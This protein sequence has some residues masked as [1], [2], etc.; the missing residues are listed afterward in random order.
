MR[1]RRP[2]QS[3][4]VCWTARAVSRF[5]LIAPAKLWE[6]LRQ[7]QDRMRCRLM[8]GCCSTA[9]GGVLDLAFAVGVCWQ[10]GARWRPGVQAAHS[11]ERD[12][13]FDEAAFDHLG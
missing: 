7:D 4:D 2:G 8:L 10:S 9:T 1:A 12:S 11:V 6:H 5:G 13:G 3:H